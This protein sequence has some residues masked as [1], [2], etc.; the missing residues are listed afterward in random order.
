MYADSIDP[1][2][3]WFYERGFEAVMDETNFDRL[4]EEGIMK[5]RLMTG[6]MKK[7]HKM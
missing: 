4:S 2:M 1:I 6:L 3:P 7:Y 5:M